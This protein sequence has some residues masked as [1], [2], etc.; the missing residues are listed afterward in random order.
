M[1][2]LINTAGIQLQIFCNFAIVK[3]VEK[4]TFDMEVMEENTFGLWPEWFHECLM[5][6]GDGQQKIFSVRYDSNY[7]PCNWW[8]LPPNPRSKKFYFRILM[9]KMNNPP[10]LWQMD[11]DAKMDESKRRKELGTLLCK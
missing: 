10:D 9:T 11:F 2:Y 3:G 5:T 7:Q 4:Q 8:N 6:M 1:N